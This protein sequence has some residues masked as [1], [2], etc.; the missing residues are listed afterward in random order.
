MEDF[1]RL[2]LRVLTW[3]GGGALFLNF[4]VLVFTIN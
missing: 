2:P 1:L 3:G 4:S